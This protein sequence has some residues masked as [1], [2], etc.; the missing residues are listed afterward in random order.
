VTTA[1]S[2]SHAGD[3]SPELVIDESG[4]A[5]LAWFHPSSGWGA[6]GCATPE[7]VPTKL[8]GTYAA[9]EKGGTFNAKR[10]TKAFGPLALAVDGSTKLGRVLVAGDDGKLRLVTEAKDGSWAGTT[11]DSGAW[12]A[13]PVLLIRQSAGTMVASWVRDGKVYVRMRG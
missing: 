3:T 8:D 13:S 5:H 9:T 6:L 4:R 11:L 1:V 12:I 10:I 2:G 7:I